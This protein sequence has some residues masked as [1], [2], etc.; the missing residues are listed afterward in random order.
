MSEGRNRL[1]D[2]TS[3][4][5][6]QHAHNPVHWWPW[7]EEALAEAQRTNRPILLS[8]GY[9]ACHWCHVMAHES[10]ESPDVAAVMN[11]LFVNIKVDREERPDVD[12]IYMQ[13]LHL[14]GEH[15]GWPLTMFCTPAGE[16][17]WG[18]TYFPYPARFGRPSFVDV[19]RGVAQAWREKPQDIETNRTGLL[20]ALRE[21]AT[22]KAV[23]ASG[24]GPIIPLRLLDQIAARLA[25]ACD[26]VWGGFGQAPKFPSP[27]VF[28]NIWR[29]WLRGRKEAK[30][31][32]A[33]TV[34]L[35]RMCQGGIY[36]HLGGGFA[37]YATD[38]HWLIPH[39]EK[40]LYDNAQLVDL[41][42]LAWQETK[43]PLY[44]TRIA[45]T[46][47]WVLR[48]MVAE[49]GGFAATYDADSEGVEGKF[50]V[51]DAAEIDAILGADDG[52]F[53]RQV[54]DVTPEGNWEHHNILHRNTSPALL[55]DAEERRLAA[56]R[57]KVKAVR[58]KRV[59]P[60]WDDK[61]LA[62]WNGL[63]IAALANVAAVFQRDD[64][65][66]AAV[67][68]W[69]FVMDT[70]RDENG[71]LFHSHRAGKRLHR[72]TLD[73]YANMARAGIALFETTGE[74]HYRDETQA[75]IGV[76]D[77]HF[78]DPQA[79][80]YFIT[81]DD[82]A[83]L[84]VRNKHCHDNAVPSGNGTLVGVFARL[85]I[86]TADVVWR[87]KAER[88]VEAF[89]GELQGNFFPLMTFLNG[90][91]TLHG[92]TELVLVGAPGDPATEALRRAI[93]H[94]S[95][96][97]KI[98][99]RLAPDALLPP[100]HPAAGKGLVNGKPALYVCRDMSCEAP[101]TEPSQFSLT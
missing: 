70:M 30:L 77:R 89:A 22:N 81:A 60:G 96:P 42:T 82:A 37:R 41:L 46:C 74:A 84:I 32:D 85:W 5:L 29:G 49:G 56:L 65:L 13:A 94:K 7:G 8:I 21:K 69:R 3:P 55:G 95:L 45:E 64:W 93:Y 44:A 12:A 58:D 98:V 100:D 57:A 24:D 11:E 83:D 51:W 92:A 73:D 61:V 90:Y 101:V 59:W 91:E 72:G 50:Y 35:D 9:A 26:P 54:Y 76:L 14:L 75:L 66:A 39:F 53:F 31:F 63:M 17:F 19:L 48:E 62:D 28:E 78:A 20:K 1:G 88:Q 40:M 4:Y 2:Q 15:G 6:L 68:A 34:T 97:N 27:Y 33:V 47:D 43:S 36:D 23:V 25:D 99:R 86:L 38:E 18:G 52:A 67:R 79:G 71:R 80:G 10:F 16:P 87:E